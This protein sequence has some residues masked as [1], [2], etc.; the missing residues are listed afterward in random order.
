[1]PEYAETE[2]IPGIS[3]AEDKHRSAVSKLSIKKAVGPVGISAEKYRQ[4]HQK[5]D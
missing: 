5:K 1:M 4:R 3:Q 2:S